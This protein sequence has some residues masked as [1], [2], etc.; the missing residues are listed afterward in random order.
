MNK[1]EKIAMYQAELPKFVQ[2]VQKQT[3]MVEN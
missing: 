3:T 2:T 1:K